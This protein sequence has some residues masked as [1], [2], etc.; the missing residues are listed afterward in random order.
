MSKPMQRDVWLHYEDDFGGY[1]RVRR[2]GRYLL[3]VDRTDTGGYG[4]CGYAWE[5]KPLRGE[6]QVWGYAQFE[7]VAMT[8]ALNMARRLERGIK[9]PAKSPQGTATH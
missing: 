6:W 3:R 7:D 5:V 4:K 2:H 8:A 1:A 9:R